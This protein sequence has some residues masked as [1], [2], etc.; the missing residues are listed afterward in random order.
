MGKEKQ[1]KKTQYKIMDWDISEKDKLK[2]LWSLF[3]NQWL[4]REVYKFYEK[5]KKKTFIAQKNK[6]K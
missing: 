3:I 6:E 1:Q 2:K 5:L 4:F